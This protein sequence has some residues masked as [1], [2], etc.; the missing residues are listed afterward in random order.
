MTTLPAG[1]S[2]NSCE[3]FVPS[4]LTVAQGI[5]KVGGNILVTWVVVGKVVWLDIT[6][7]GIRGIDALGII[8]ISG[9]L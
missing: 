3:F 6:T 2:V 1:S 7:S 8:F 9:N 4:V 5:S